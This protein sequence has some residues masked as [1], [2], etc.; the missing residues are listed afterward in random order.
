M[1]VTDMLFTDI[2]RPCLD[3]KPFTNFAE[4]FVNPTVIDATSVLCLF[5]EVTATQYGEKGSS[6][7]RDI[8]YMEDEIGPGVGWQMAQFFHF[9]WSTIGCVAPPFREFVIEMD[10]RVAMEHVAEVMG[11]KV[12]KDETLHIGK[13]AV[14][15]TT[16]KREDW[17]DDIERGLDSKIHSD[18]LAEFRTLAFEWMFV[19]TVFRYVPGQGLQG[20]TCTWIIPVD[21][22]G[23]LLIDPRANEGRVKDEVLGECP[24]M[25]HA[26][27]LGPWCEEDVDRG[28]YVRKDQYSRSTQYAITQGWMCVIP[29]LLALSAMHTPK[30]KGDKPGLHEVE[31]GEAPHRKVAK[32][33]LEKNFRPMVRWYTLKIDG[34]RQA[35]REANGGEMPRNLS[36]L[37][38]ALHSVRGHTRT[39]MPNT[40]F[41]R[42]H[43]QPITVFVPAHNRGN[44]K[45]GVVQKDYEVQV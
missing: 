44:P 5:H 14:A 21:A 2:P 36:D 13:T 45:H 18:A 23:R 29:A 37:R 19:V 39:Y 27:S 8:A 24:P 1:R 20:P 41:G 3:D 28:G 40:Y 11:V 32:R 15:F 35:L 42:K 16:W 30:T 34:L 38:L 22:D 25:I 43:D 17:Y 4:M 31:E 26:M 7:R 12:D 10:H 33:Y 9:D 6:L